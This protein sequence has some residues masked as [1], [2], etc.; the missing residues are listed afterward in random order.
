MYLLVFINCVLEIALKSELSTSGLSLS[1][2]PSWALWG[3]EQHPGPLPVD[4]GA[5]PV[6]TTTNVSPCCQMSLGE[7]PLLS[8]LPLEPQH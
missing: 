2:Q 4:L 1:W 6:V 3:I 8:P 5:P 7:P